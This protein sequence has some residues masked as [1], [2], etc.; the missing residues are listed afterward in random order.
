MLYKLKEN[1]L[2]SIAFE[3]F[4]NIG[5]KKKILKIFLPKTWK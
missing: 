3:D 5:K 2:E 4:G 1:E